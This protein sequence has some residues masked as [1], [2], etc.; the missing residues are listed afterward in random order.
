MK[1]NEIQGFSNLKRTKSY[2]KKKQ[3]VRGLEH[4]LVWKPLCS[5]SYH[6]KRWHFSYFTYNLIKKKN[7]GLQSNLAE[8]NLFK[9]IEKN[10]FLIEYV[11][12]SV[13]CY[14]RLS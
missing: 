14:W 7:G 8:K 1:R 13:F 3:N 5:I 4:F 9:T 11:I 10:I 6:F 12:L 2:M